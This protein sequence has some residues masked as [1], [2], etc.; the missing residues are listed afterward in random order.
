VTAKIYQNA[1]PTYPVLQWITQVSTVVEST[2]RQDWPSTLSTVTVTPKTN[3]SKFLLMVHAA[4]AAG[5]AG[6]FKDGVEMFDPLYGGC[7]NDNSTNAT[8]VAV[9][10]PARLTPVT[11]AVYYRSFN[12][13]VTY[14]NNNFGG[15]MPGEATLHVIELAY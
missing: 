11:Y 5:V 12:G 8:M 1:N 3:T 4:Q 9:D 13:N 2:T 14:W 6:F 15:A 10:F 7:F